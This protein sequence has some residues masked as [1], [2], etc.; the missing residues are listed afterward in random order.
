VGGKPAGWQ[1]E[2]C[3]AELPGVPDDGVPGLPAARGGGGPVPCHVRHELPVGSSCSAM[4]IVCCR[5]VPLQRHVCH[6]LLV[7][8]TAE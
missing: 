7:G 6:K 4:F 8:T 5:W 3:G 1:E 2:R